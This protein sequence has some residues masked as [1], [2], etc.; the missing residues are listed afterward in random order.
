MRKA[1]DH[2]VADE[3]VHHPAD[4]RRLHP[5]TPGELDLREAVP[6]HE[7]QKEA[8]SLRADDLGRKPHVDPAP[9][10]PP[11]HREPVA[12][13]VVEAGRGAGGRIGHGRGNI[14]IMATVRQ[15]P[16]ARGGDLRWWRNDGDRASPGQEDDAREC[17]RICYEAIRIHP[18]ICRVF[19]D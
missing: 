9:Q 5:L 2:P 12:Q 6:L 8:E 4:R 11:R 1:L 13:E 3:A 18:A 19:A 15:L 14:L 7:P 17:G 16:L 10:Q